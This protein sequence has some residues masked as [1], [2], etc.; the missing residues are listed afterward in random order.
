MWDEK[1][2]TSFITDEVILFSSNVL[3]LTND[4]STQLFSDVSRKAL[5][6]S[7]SF[8]GLKCLPPEDLSLKKKIT[9]LNASEG[10]EQ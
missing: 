4:P 10:G 1:K 2:N 5:R 9:A 6:K 3:W 8:W 7:P